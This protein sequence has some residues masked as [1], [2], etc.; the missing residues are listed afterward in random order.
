MACPQQLPLSAR[1]GLLGTYH[2]CNMLHA[3]TTDPGQWVRL[4][5]RAQKDVT[6][7]LVPTAGADSVKEVLEIWRERLCE[8]VKPG[9]PLILSISSQNNV[10]KFLEM[11]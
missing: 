4:L 9:I 7:R 8:G 11:Q 6:W 10:F 3:P 1:K 5:K 2:G